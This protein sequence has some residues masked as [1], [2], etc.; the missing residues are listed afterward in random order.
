MAFAL[1]FGLAGKELA[2]EY[3]EKKLKGE[4]RESE[5]RHL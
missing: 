1:A 3:L 4:E 5:I 2:R